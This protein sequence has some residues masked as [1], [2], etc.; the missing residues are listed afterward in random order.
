MSI[1][2]PQC[3]KK[4]NDTAR[5]CSAC[6]FNLAGTGKNN[7]Y[8]EPSRQDGNRW[9][10][11][12]SA[13]PE[14]RQNMGERQDPGYPTVND[15]PPVNEYPP[16][17]GYTLD[18][19]DR[20]DK[21]GSGTR[22]ALLIF[23]AVISLMIISLSLVLLRSQF[24]DQ[25]TS[26]TAEAKS[27]K[28]GGKGEETTR[29]E[30][31]SDTDVSTTE[32]SSRETTEY[33]DVSIEEEDDTAGFDYCDNDYINITYHSEVSD[34]QLVN[35]EDGSFTFSYPKYIFNHAEVN[36]DGSDYLF[37]YRNEYGEDDFVLR[38][39]KEYDPGNAKDIVM[40]HQKEYMSAYSKVLY[41][42]DYKRDKNKG[43]QHISIASGYI[44]ASE[45]RG[46]YAL[47]END[48]EYTY[49]MVFVY[50]ECS[51]EENNRLQYI[52]NNVYRQC[53]FAMSKKKAVSYEEMLKEDG[54]ITLQ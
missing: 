31:A 3:G 42:Y 30:A 21:S 47:V 11:N 23:A 25:S 36:E 18:E 38:Y 12:Y 33:E 49:R 8:Q 17:R 27:G 7:Q 41:Q 13:S 40:G 29:E 39:T 35:S 1:T 53:S 2:C 26:E 10:R 28:K 50:D 22:K 32:S 44:N 9:G 48:G 16:G 20:G 6:G 51:G 15:Y 43:H 14:S 4:N 52:I 46:Q 19:K 24:S 5:F 54:T 34:F 37:T 45:S